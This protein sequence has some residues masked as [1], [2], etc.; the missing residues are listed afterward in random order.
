MMKTASNDFQSPANRGNSPAIAKLA[1]L[2]LLGGET[3]LFGTLVSSYLFVR[4][5]AGV[6]PSYTQA[7]LD[8]LWLPVVNTLVLLLSAAAAWYAA[9]SINKGRRGAMQ[10]GLTWSLMLGLM[11]VA[12]QVIEFS[13]S[14]LSPVDAAFGG[15]YLAL[16]SFHAVHVLAGVVLLGLDLLRARLGDFTANSHTVVDVSAW[17]WY[18]VTAVWLVL[19]AVLYFV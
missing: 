15:M 11:F 1:L 8:R 5:E 7:G 16:I 14:G 4:A 3:I 12:L 13:K 10:N 6:A 17:F 9:R 18:Y 2:V 19:F